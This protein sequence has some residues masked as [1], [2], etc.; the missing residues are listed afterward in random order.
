MSY[1]TISFMELLDAIV[2]LRKIQTTYA[3]I[4]NTHLVCMQKKKRF[5]SI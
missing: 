4:R 5:L 2:S 1:L 3:E